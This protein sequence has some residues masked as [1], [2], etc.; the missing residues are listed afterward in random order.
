MG[1]ARNRFAAFVAIALLGL[2]PSLLAQPANGRVNGV[3]RDASGAVVPGATVT[4]T[5]QA[6]KATHTAT[7]AADGSYSLSVPAG[8]Y[9]ASAV[10]RRVAHQSLRDLK[11]ESGATLTTDFALTTQL[12]EEITVTSLKR[13]STLLEV[14]FSVAAR[15]P[16]TSCA[17]AASTTSRA[18]L[19]TWR[20]SACRTWAPGRARSR[21]EASPPA[22]L[23]AT[24]PASRSRWAPTSTSR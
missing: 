3:V 13:E 15:R 17:S 9:T 12:S 20:A 11:L 2:V 6:T 14:P 23:R 1:V 22:R 16:R 8:V 21:S 24:S 18:W 4:L 5:N 10:V 7:S 19:A